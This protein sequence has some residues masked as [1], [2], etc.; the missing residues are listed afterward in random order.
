MKFRYIST[1]MA[2]LEA[3]PLRHII[4]TSPLGACLPWW[5]WAGLYARRDTRVA[6]LVY[7]RVLARA[8][9]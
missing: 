7:D 6:D 9:H 8:G 5:S 3:R 4:A 2:E 1:V